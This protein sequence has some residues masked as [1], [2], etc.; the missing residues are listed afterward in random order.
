MALWPTSV[1]RLSST[2]ACDRPHLFDRFGPSRRQWTKS[3]R[4]LLRRF[5]DGLNFRKAAAGNSG[6][7]PNSISGT[8]IT[9][10]NL[11]GVFAAA[12]GSPRVLTLTLFRHRSLVG[13]YGSADGL[14]FRWQKVRAN[15]LLM[16]YWES[17]SEEIVPSSAQVASA[18][19]LF[20]SDKTALLGY[21][22]WR[23]KDGVIGD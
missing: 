1:L 9:W 13:F 20:P 3:L 23:A 17:R 19:S 7:G 15:R 11:P 21:N 8:A 4:L 18:V 2:E 5:D 10:G 22:R 6:E 14:D 12:G 16:S